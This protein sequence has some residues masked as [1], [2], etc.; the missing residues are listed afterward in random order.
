MVSGIIPPIG[1]STK[2]PVDLGMGTVFAPEFYREAVR[3]VGRE[4]NVDMLLVICFSPDAID[5]VLEAKKDLKKPLVIALPAITEQR[6]Y[7]VSS[8]EVV[9]AY[10]SDRR[11]AK[12][13]A[14]LADYKDF[15]ERQK[16]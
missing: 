7:K 2:N 11:A 12:V 13:L 3:I 5:M 4:D 1:T 9:P 6:E 8:G 14:A 10:P 16:A 15:L